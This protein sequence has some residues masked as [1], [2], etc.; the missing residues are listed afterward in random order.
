MALHLVRPPL[1][2]TKQREARSPY[3]LVLPDWKSNPTEAMVPG[4]ARSSNAAWAERLDK[5]WE[6]HGVAR[7][8]VDDGD[9]DAEEDTD[10]DGPMPKTSKNVVG[11]VLQF[12]RKPL[13]NGLSESTAVALRARESPTALRVMG[14][15]GAGLYTFALCAGAAGPVRAPDRVVMARVRRATEELAG[16]CKPAMQ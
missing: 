1:V 4:R 12:G 9:D 11:G 14:L 3:A 10:E 8:D 13:P 5:F 2:S 7:Q 6:A 16:E 15:D